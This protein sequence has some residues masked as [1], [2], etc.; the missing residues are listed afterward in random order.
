MSPASVK[1]IHAVLHKALKQA[2]M[3][4]LV[5]ENAAEATVKPKARAEEIKPLDT[6]RTKALC[7]Q[8]SRATATKRSTRSP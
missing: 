1:L 7:W 8:P 6:E 2:Q 5:R 3:W 4:R